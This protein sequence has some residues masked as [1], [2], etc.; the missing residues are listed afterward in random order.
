MT[1][2]MSVDPLHRFQSSGDGDGN[3]QGD[4]SSDLDDFRLRSTG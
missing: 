4:R 3:R 1:R 2:T